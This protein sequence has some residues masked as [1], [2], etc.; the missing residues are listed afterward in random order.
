M[1]LLRDSQSSHA[2]SLDMPSQRRLYKPD[3]RLA[4]S[5]GFRVSHGTATD[6]DDREATGGRIA[7]KS[8]FPRPAGLPRETKSPCPLRYFSSVGK[9]DN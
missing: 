4:A 1:Q 6:L 8:F 9:L 2:H 5:W 3:A 7:L